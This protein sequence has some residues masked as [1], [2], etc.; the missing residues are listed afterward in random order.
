MERFKSLWPKGDHIKVLE[1]PHLDPEERIYKAVEILLTIAL[2]DQEFERQNLKF[3]AFVMGKTR[4]YFRAGALEF[5]EGERLRYLGK[6]AILI[7]TQVRG[8][9]MK[10]KYLKHKRSVI[11]LQSGYRKLVE[12]KQYLVIRNSVVK[13]QCWYRILCAA[14]TIFHLRRKKKS[15]MI[16]TRWRI[17]CDRR[18][19]LKMKVAA[20]VVQTMVRGG[21]QRPKYRQALIDKKEEAKLENQLVALQR[22]LE[23]AEAKRVEAEKQAEAQ[24]AAA[25]QQYKE[26]HENQDEP[27]TDNTTTGESQT[28]NQGHDTSF[29]V[30][31]QTAEQ[32]KL[33]DESGRM[34]E[35]LRKEV[36]KLR[37][38]RR[39]KIKKQESEVK[40]TQNYNLNDE[41]KIDKERIINGILE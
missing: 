30:D 6:F 9:V 25:V 4:A 16:Q 41:L 1:D 40:E 21:L 28:A 12:R 7:Q 8:F 26:E 37:A 15:T 13:V 32:Q 20:V 5:L 24:A 29:E 19:F 35:Y 18:R 34:L 23:E 10:A 11:T 33:M 27:Q 36:F 3:R 22:K 39:K 38:I 17:Y 14:R 2:K 31:E